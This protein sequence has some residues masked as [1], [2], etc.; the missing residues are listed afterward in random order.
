MDRQRKSTLRYQVNE[1]RNVVPNEINQIFS[2]VQKQNKSGPLLAKIMKKYPAPLESCSIKR[3]Y[4][5]QGLLKNRLGH[6]SN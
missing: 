5:Y 4:L 6:Y 3:F 1:N 2:F